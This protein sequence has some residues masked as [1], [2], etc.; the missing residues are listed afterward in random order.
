MVD[1]GTGLAV[2]GG[3]IGSKELIQK[4]LGPSADYLGAGLAE[5]T[6]R[7]IKNTARVFA[8]AAKK[9]GRG[10]DGPG[11]VPPK[12]LKGILSEAP[13]CDDELGAEYFGGVLASS[14]SEVGRDDRGA[15]FLGVIGRLSTYQIRSHFVFYSIIHVLYKDLGENIGVPGGRQRLRTFVPIESYATAMEFGPKED[16]AQILSHVMFG[17]ARETLIEEHFLFGD[18]ELIKVLYPGAARHGILF[19]PSVLG[20]ELFLWAHG[21][22]NLGTNDI[23]TAALPPI[24]VSITTSEHRAD[25]G[26]KF[27][28][29]L[30]ARRYREGLGAF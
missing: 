14:R 6:E 20:V 22:S 8:K 7:A 11:A 12:V 19:E 9:L 3:A 29:V 27:R 4:V 24:D 2:L 15:A 30:L 5:W 13:F 18:P 16:C 26:F 23:L 17:L 1:P 10:I 21:K 25:D 28:N